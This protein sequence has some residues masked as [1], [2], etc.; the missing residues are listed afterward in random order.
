M[1]GMC[2]CTSTGT[3]IS[4]FLSRKR[5]KEGTGK[6]ETGKARSGLHGLG[7]SSNLW[8]QQKKVKYLVSTECLKNN[9]CLQRELIVEKAE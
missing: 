2:R 6:R 4:L 1:F 3:W 5:K 8:Y 7:C 9:I